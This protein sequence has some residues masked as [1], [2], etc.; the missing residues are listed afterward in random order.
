[1]KSI[2]SLLLLA[3]FFDS[4]GQEKR[5][6]FITGFTEVDTVYFHCNNPF[7]QLKD[8]Q[9]NDT[10]CSINFSKQRIEFK[11]AN[12]KEIPFSYK[13]IKANP[14]SLSYYLSDM[15]MMPKIKPFSACELWGCDHKLVI[16]K[17]TKH[18]ECWI[19]DNKN[20]KSR[21]S[22]WTLVFKLKYT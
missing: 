2:L 19:K 16:A 15:T 17:K 12:G 6:F 11:Y 9:K 14:D 20:K 3:Y 5:H 7:N 21:Y 22:K 18:I 1:M 8:N 4:Y 13:Q 10:I